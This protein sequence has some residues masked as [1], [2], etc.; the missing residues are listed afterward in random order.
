MPERKFLLNA[1]TETTNFTT[2]RYAMEIRKVWPKIILDNCQ[3]LSHRFHNG[4]L[5][6]R[7]SLD[8]IPLVM[9]ND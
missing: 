2:K 8:K 5:I 6:P 1:H 4:T 9:E 3:R 7:N